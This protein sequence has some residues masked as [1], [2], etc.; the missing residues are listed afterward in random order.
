MTRL[1]V[2]YVRRGWLWPLLLRLLLLP[3][4]L[5][6]A[7]VTT[8]DA[9]PHHARITA[10]V[11]A[12]AAD[13]ASG[14]LP[15]TVYFVVADE[16]GRA[17][18][19]PPL[20]EDGAAV[21]VNGRPFP[22]TLAPYTGDSTITL[23]TDTTQSMSGHMPAILTAFLN[24]FERKPANVLLALTGF[25]QESTTVLDFS[26]D[27]TALHQAS[28]GL[29]TT[30]E[31]LS[32]PFDAA[33][34]AINAASLDDI[35]QASPQVMR[36]VVLLSDG[37]NNGRCTY[38]TDRDLDGLI[39]LATDKQISFYT[40]RFGNTA[41]DDNARLERLAA[42]TG[43]TSYRFTNAERP[44]QLSEHLNAIAA[45]LNTQQQAQAIVFTETDEPVSVNLELR[46][47]G[48][49]N[50][51]TPLRSTS[52]EFTPPPPGIFR[53]IFKQLY[54]EDSVVYVPET[55]ALAV[56]LLGANMSGD[57][58][59]RL[60]IYDS[61]A[62]T[63]VPSTEKA[64][65]WETA[66]ERR[67]EILPAEGLVGGREYF[68]RVYSEDVPSPAEAE[69]GAPLSER[70]YTH[71]E[72]APPPPFRLSL[73]PPD[74]QLGQ[75]AVELIGV[76]VPAEGRTS[77]R[78]AVAIDGTPVYPTAAV[79]EQT[80]TSAVEPLIIPY[81][82]TEEASGDRQ[83]VAAD[84]T[85]WLTWPDGRQSSATIEDA[86]LPLRPRVGLMG[87][88][89][90]A[91]RANPVIA[92]VIL[93]VLGFALFYLLALRRMNRLN[94][95][96]TWRP[97]RA[98]TRTPDA[99]PDDVAASPATESQVAGVPS[100]GSL[101]A[102]APRPALPPLPAHSPLAATLRVVRAP[103]A[104]R[105]GEIAVVNRFPFRIGREGC[106]LTIGDG[107][108]SRHHASIQQ[109]GDQLVI[110]DKSSKNGTY[111]NDAT[112][113]LTPGMR[114]PMQDGDRIRIGSTIELHL[115][116]HPTGDAAPGSG[117]PTGP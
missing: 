60:H 1:I 106:E 61:K 93:V 63:V 15:L 18:P 107:R 31:R 45:G 69:V 10:I 90:G 109:I 29:A 57:E 28:R 27:A 38:R 54:L 75:L 14:G 117:K 115:A 104:D 58:R 21:L 22:A 41:P 67:E 20:V 105:E 36:A 99:P 9:P 62:G 30:D 48:Q 84:I 50:E 13:P 80:L 68:I 6:A 25:E 77:Y 46:V 19:R 56:V 89:G 112:D 111:L 55:Q 114:W 116:T 8:Q 12:D 103:D 49:G 43:G 35:L 87:R 82:P 33:Y 51:T 24:L 94:P 17:L 97:V 101:P 92:G 96:A 32:C 71:G 11:P 26:A 88:L 100:A 98:L 7:Q 42:A 47:R 16:S 64:I 65:V 39:E 91:L 52:T 108:T 113:P 110:I 34:D 86:R 78:A 76:V 53:P 102:A 40:I 85:V 5:L 66:Q 70:R 2:R 59:V 72:I 83:S 73:R 81:Y 79:G 74:P 23:L 44:E 4:A 3:A 95:A 37:V